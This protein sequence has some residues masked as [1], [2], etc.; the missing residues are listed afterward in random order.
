MGWLLVNKSK[1]K[2]IIGKL[3]EDFVESLEDIEFYWEWKPSKKK[4]TD[5]ED[6][7]SK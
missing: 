4:H 5:L 1:P 6:C 3:N 2:K 7:I